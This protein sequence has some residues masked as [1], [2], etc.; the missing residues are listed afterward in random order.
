[1][2]KYTYIRNFAI[3]TRRTLDENRLIISPSAGID[4]LIFTES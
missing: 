3:A 1:M 2:L 4:I